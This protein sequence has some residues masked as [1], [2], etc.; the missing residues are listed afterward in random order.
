M[1]S[2][3]GGLFFVMEGV[4]IPPPPNAPFAILLSGSVGLAVFCSLDSMMFLC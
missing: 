4:F 3:F 2:P 1:E